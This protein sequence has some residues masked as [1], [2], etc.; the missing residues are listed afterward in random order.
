MDLETECK[1]L[2]QSLEEVRSQSITK[3]ESLAKELDL[4]QNELDTTISD[5]NQ[6]EVEV[7]ILRLVRDDYEKMKIQCKEMESTI[8]TLLEKQDNDLSKYSE[9]TTVL[10]GQ[11]TEK[12]NIIKGMEQKYDELEDLLHDSAKKCE[13]LSKLIDTLKLEKLNKETSDIVDKDDKIAK[14][15]SDF[16]EEITKK[17][18]ILEEKNHALSENKELIEL[19][20]QENIDIKAQCDTLQS[21][22]DELKTSIDNSERIEDEQVTDRLNELETELESQ[23]Q[24]NRELSENVKDLSNDVKLITESKESLQAELNQVM[25][26]RGKF[27][28]ARYT[29]KISELEKK[30]ELKDSQ[31]GNMAEQQGQEMAFFKGI[32]DKKSEEIE[33]LKKTNKRLASA[34]NHV[35]I[36][37]QMRQLSS[38][39]AELREE[40]K[41]IKSEGS[42]DLK[43][44]NKLR[45]HAQE[46]RIL[47]M[48][49]A[50]LIENVQEYREQID[51]LQEE[52]ETLLYKLQKISNS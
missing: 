13:E 14:I 51:L 3:E 44:M 29:M 46:L 6:I 31:L 15:I 37:N 9:E 19:L 39:N 11:V 8:E 33:M 1:N 45:L 21:T 48:G 34:E 17:D 12:E 20:Q 41:R 24:I 52:K 22:V 43:E 23:K 26:E 5:K 4:V 16:N 38:E 18:S 28:S 30:M 36:A 25:E 49:S 32:I 50:K 35:N 2:K 47:S 27:D 42:I 40:L 10:K 7:N